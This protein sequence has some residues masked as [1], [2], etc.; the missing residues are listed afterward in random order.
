MARILVVDDEPDIRDVVGGVL[1]RA[2]HNVTAA[3]DGASAA[4]L[5]HEHEF[6]L[7][8]SDLRMPGFSGIQLAKAI[9]ADSRCGIPILLVTASAS[10]QDLADAHR[11]G[12]TAYLG[13]PFTLTELRDKVAFMLAAA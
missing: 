10:R 7:I 5:H 9:R 3:E 6:D 12:V 1:E 4:R 8:V 11:A 2:G 13:K